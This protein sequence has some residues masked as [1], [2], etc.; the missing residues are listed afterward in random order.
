MN[1]KKAQINQ[2]FVYLLSIIMI[3]F[4]G[5]LVIK[6]IYSFS[7]DTENSLDVKFFNK[8]DKDYL[9]VYSSY[10]SE[11]TF[12]YKVSSKIELICFANKI[13]HCES[14]KTNISDM[15]YSNF[16]LSLNS[17]KQIALFDKLGILNSKKLGKFNV[18]NDCLCVKPKNGR[19]KLFFENI[20]NKVTLSNSN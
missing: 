4:I 12:S 9:K 1:S 2:V 19:F 3:L 17:K 14:I 20:K 15:A 11:E 10:G 5:F 18:L 8:I 7:N 6:F 13:D 16:N